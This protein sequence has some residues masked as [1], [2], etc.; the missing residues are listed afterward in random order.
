MKYIEK[1]IGNEPKTLKS[2]RDT[3]PEASFK[4]FTDTDHLLKKA[5]LAEQ[6]H[7]CAY[8][9]Q[10]IS[11]KLNAKHKPRIEVEHILSQEN[12]PYKSLD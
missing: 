9:M 6:G 10:R 11:L 7:I 2:Y 3:T 5:L 8:C 4:G 12:H 1:K